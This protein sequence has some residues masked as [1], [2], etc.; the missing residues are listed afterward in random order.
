MR[1]LENTFVI[2]IVEAK[3]NPCNIFQSLQWHDACS[4]ILSSCTG[5]LRIASPYRKCEGLHTC[6]DRNIDPSRPYCFQGSS[7]VKVGWS[8]PPRQTQ[9]LA[10][11]FESLHF[12]S[13]HFWDRLVYYDR[14][15]SLFQ[16]SPLRSTAIQKSM[17]ERTKKDEAFPTI[18][19]HDAG[20][21]GIRQDHCG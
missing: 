6:A 15:S 17:G 4:F 3:I 19:L 9:R 20:A 14:P 13:L 21:H 2:T 12:E 16:D 8:R 1:N 10:M 5:L 7:W 11:C 18:V